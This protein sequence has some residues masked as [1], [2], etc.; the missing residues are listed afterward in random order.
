MKVDEAVGLAIAK[1]GASRVFGVVGSGNFRTTNAL[2]A[3]GLPFVASRH[4]MGAACMADAYARSTGR[5][6]VVSVHQGCGL[7]NA[8]TG[9]GEAAKSRTPVLVVSG[10]TPG[11]EYESN[12]WI[13]QDKVVE[14]MGAVPERIHTPATAI[15][16]TVRAV[17]TA[18]NRRRTVVL[19]LPLDLQRQDLPP[20]QQDLLERLA[21]PVPPTVPVA[22]PESV[23]RLA[24]L[25][26]GAER[27]VIVGGRGAAHAVPEIRH[28]A[29]LAG[30]LL[31]TSAV[32]RGLFHEDPWH[33]DVMGGFSTEG[34]AELISQADVLV[35]FGAA[36]NRWTTR[37]GWFLRNKTVVQVDDTLRA[38]GFHYPVDVEVLGD[39]AL[40]AAA[41]AAE[42]E[43]RGGVPHTGYRTEDVSRKV[44][45]SLN[46]S[47]QPYDDTSEPVDPAVPGSGRID[48]RTLTNAIDRMVPMER[49]VVPDGGNFN[50]YPAMNLRVPDNR[51]YCVPL[52]LQSIGLALSSAIGSSVASPERVTIA[53][54]GD[55]GFMM[56]LVELDTAVRLQ[57]PLIVV[58]Y[59]DNAYGAEVHHFEHETDRLDTV[60]F[61]E[62]D[63]AAIA[64]GFGCE[65]ITVR[66]EE[67]LE[68]LRAW[69]DG[70][71]DRPL[72][73]DAKITAFP[74][75][76]L[77]HSFAEHE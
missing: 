33:L 77:A 22:A 11:G 3:A 68:P 39:T 75:W 45:E 34:A 38:F 76:V 30:A 70:A 18:V 20:S 37:D 15:R 51:G 65:G 31:T 6:T 57:L 72:V 10:D 4:E 7:S 1:M 13:D 16:D 52:A 62:T 2:T 21:P 42:L 47:D 74:S 25:L 63:I 48:P 36:L 56:S 44:A 32:G 61:P 53:G 59:N 35:A 28:L 73:I 27:P 41:V 66:A 29:E 8:L 64:R 5:L 43:S 50:A 12:F 24:D 17:R 69:L 40:T 60:V 26:A 14:G 49:V 23:S 67:D 58:V 9:I 19:S 54:I 55:G 71:R 46:W